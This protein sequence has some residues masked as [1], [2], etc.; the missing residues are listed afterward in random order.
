VFERKQQHKARLLAGMAA[1]RADGDLLPGVEGRP[2]LIEWLR[3]PGNCSATLAP[4]AALALG[5]PPARGVLSSIEIE[6]KYAGYIVQQDRQVER[7]RRAEARR[8]PLQFR[9]D[10]LP[11][12]SREI[13]DRL[14]RVRPSTLGQAARIPGVTPAAVAILDV[15]LSL[16]APRPQ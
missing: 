8:I 15:Y 3:R 14:E 11:G 12:L 6:A 16:G 9:Y 2:T 13:R 10:G 5:E 4:W 7:L 1:T